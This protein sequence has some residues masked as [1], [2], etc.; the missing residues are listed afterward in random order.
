VKAKEAEKQADERDKK[1]FLNL[2]DRE[3]V[4]CMFWEF[5][6]SGKENLETLLGWL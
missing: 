6:P 2:S 4:S 3:K 5:Q 1:R